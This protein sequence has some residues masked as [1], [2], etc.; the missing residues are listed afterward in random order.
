MT[1]KIDWFANRILYSVY[2]ALSFLNLIIIWFIYWLLVY[3]FFYILF[4]IKRMKKASEKK[5][6]GSFR[7][8]VNELLSHFDPYS[9]AKKNYDRQNI[10]TLVLY[11]PI[12]IFVDVI[13]IIINPPLMQVCTQRWN[14]VLLIIVKVLF[15]ALLSNYFFWRKNKYLS[16]FKTFEKEH[17]TK[18]IVWVIGASVGMFL[19]AVIDLNLM[20]YIMDINR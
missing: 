20:F 11:L 15:S 17:L 4:I 12:S 14:L 13:A 3:P 6:N 16:Y 1:K 2:D 10:A 5:D 18:R 7:K 8:E 19:L 9:Y